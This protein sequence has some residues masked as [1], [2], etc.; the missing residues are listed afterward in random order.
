[1]YKKTIGNDMLLASLA[2]S[3]AAAEPDPEPISEQVFL[4]SL[5][6]D[7]LLSAVAAK[8]E[9]D[10]RALAASIAIEWALDSSSELADIYAL[11]YAAVLDDDEAD[12]VELTPEQDEQY[13]TLLTL[14]ADA[15]INIGGNTEKSVQAMLDDESE[16]AALSV[17]EKIREA[18]KASSV[19]ELVAD[20]SVHEELIASA[21]KKVVRNGKLKLI[22]KRTRKIRLSAPQRSALKKARLRANT[23]AAKAKRRKSNRIR[24]RAGL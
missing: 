6:E 4:S 10:D 8:A 21:M 22:K 18:T 16:E 24:S 12:D 20:F 15:F 2:A 23:S 1:M 11:I 14:T 3:A 7:S 9:Q 19:D 17:A 5:N 13:E